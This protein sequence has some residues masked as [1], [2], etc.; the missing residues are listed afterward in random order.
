RFDNAKGSSKAELPPVKDRVQPTDGKGVSGF[1][2]NIA[3]SIRD[4]FSPGDKKAPPVDASG[5]KP[6]TASESLN[7]DKDKG[8]KTS[9]KDK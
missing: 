9:E 8:E 1:A 6:E 7:A 3:Q 5:K 2:A 4:K